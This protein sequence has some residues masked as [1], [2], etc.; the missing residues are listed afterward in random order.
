MS[1]LS[2]YGCEIEYSIKNELVS[3]D[4][5]T[6][7][8]G[9][10]VL[11]DEIEG[12]S[13]NALSRYALSGLR[14]LKEVILPK[15]LERI[16][17]LAFYNDRGLERLELPTGVFRI[18]GDA[19]KNCDGIKE[20][21]ISSERVLR[22]VLNEL[23]QEITVILKDD[24]GN[25][26]WKLLFPIEAES[27]SEDVPGR[28]FHRTFTGPGYTY[29]REAVGSKVDMRKYDGLFKR[30][31]EEE[32]EETLCLLAIFRLMYPYRLE[33]E[34][35]DEYREYLKENAVIGGRCFLDRRLYD[36]F[37]CMIREELF[38]RRAAE[39]ITQYAGKIGNAEAAARLMDYINR[40]FKPANKNFDL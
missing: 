39:K 12:K 1:H 28:A 33:D 9:R 31:T 7:C 26:V 34:Y 15:G 23:G 24:E 19:F 2:Y 3:I 4:R 14:E 8:S 27:F 37:K 20:V 13:V 18:G 29:R 40:S 22:Y 36:E 17:N 25:I 10:L 11:P 5:C 30:S 21:V 6:E 16:E 35:K 38:S 32:T